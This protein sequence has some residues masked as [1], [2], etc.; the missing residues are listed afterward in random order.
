VGTVYAYSKEQLDI[1]DTDAV[2]ETVEQLQP[3]V[4]VNAAAYTAVD[5]AE[6]E[7]DLAFAINASAV[8]SLAKL[9]HHASAW[10]IH[11]STDYVFDG[12]KSSPY[13]ETDTTNPINV[14][15][16]SKLAGEQ[17]IINSGCQYLIFRTSWVM[18]RDGNNFA[19]TILRLAEDREQLD[20]ISDQL[21]VPTSVSL[22][23]KVTNHA[24][25]SIIQGDS[26]P[27]GIYNAVPQGKTS[28]FDIA[29]AVLRIAEHHG[30]SLMAS[31]QDINSINTVDYPTSAKRPLNSLLNTK[32]VS[33]QLPFLLPHWYDD[34]EYVV[35]QII[36]EQKV[37]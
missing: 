28:W 10:L 33:Q 35:E 1:T 14:Y 26:W 29:T 37:I 3:D 34:F 6:T 20:V 5:K 18:G 12:S 31:S 21:G 36:K 32:K 17:A 23:A 22:L 30:L 16:A 8:E 11:Y 24:I 4:I 7:A 13:K 15:G 9:A 19:K 2:T 25:E 27:S